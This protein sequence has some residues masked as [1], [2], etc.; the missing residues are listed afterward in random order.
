MKT[1][2]LVIDMQKFFGKMVDRPLL[3]IRL[4][5]DY[6]NQ[7]SRPV[8]FTQ[9]GHTEEE[10]VPPIKNQ[11]IRKVGPENVLMRGSKDWELVP[12]VWK[13]A[14]DSPVVDKNT[15]D[16]FMGTDLDHVLKENDVKRV[17]ITG[18]MSDVCCNTTAISAF[19]RG[20]ETWYISDACWTDT[21]KQHERA[22]KN[23]D[24]LTGMVYKTA[25]AIAMLEAE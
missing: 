13:M 5:D 17:F 22:L 7:S 16:A 9:H 24:F 19:C 23:I 2:L 6:F 18:V 12:D 10:L 11:L 4:L 3:S 25:D 14:K 1:A 20:Y 8:I 15:Y 21:S